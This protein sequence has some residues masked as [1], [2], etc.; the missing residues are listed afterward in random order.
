[1]VWTICASSE[2]NIHAFE[3]WS[4]CYCKNSPSL[5]C[6]L[7][8]RDRRRAC[9]LP[10]S[11]LCVLPALCHYGSY[12]S[13]SRI[14]LYTRRCQ[15]VQR[16][17]LLVIQLQK[18]FPPSLPLLCLVGLSSLLLSSTFRMECLQDSNCLKQLQMAEDIISVHWKMIICLGHHLMAKLEPCNNSIFLCLAPQVAA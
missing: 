6:A 5:S 2:F 4:Q 3:P 14:Q 9:T 13:S 11:L 7:L 10:C 18:P 15:A 1:M 8:L 16:G 12:C 17:H